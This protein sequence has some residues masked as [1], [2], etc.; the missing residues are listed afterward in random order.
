MP[1]KGHSKSVTSTC[2]TLKPQIGRRI[3]VNS[4]MLWII[5][6]AP[7][8]RS[9]TISCQSAVAL[10]VCVVLSCIVFCKRGLSSCGVRVC[11]SVSL[12]RCGFC[13]KRVEISFKMILPLG[14]QSILAFP[15][16][17]ARQYSDGTPPSPPLTAASMQVW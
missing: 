2:Y 5:L 4:I 14:S 11:L 3:S 13:Q 1:F 17:M 6:I 10:S 15:Y 12:S 9:Y 7:F 16:E 8:D